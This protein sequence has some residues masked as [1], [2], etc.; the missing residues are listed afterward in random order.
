MPRD[1]ILF[2]QIRDEMRMPLAARV[3]PPG[4]L[5]LSSD[6]NPQKNTSKNAEKHRE[7]PMESTISYVFHLISYDF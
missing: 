7:T 5:G 6:P 2:L 4:S 1:A 3:Q